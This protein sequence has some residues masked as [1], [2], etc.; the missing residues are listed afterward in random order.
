LVTWT[1]T[2]DLETW[3][4]TTVVEVVEVEPL[5]FVVVEVGVVD[6]ELEAD[7]PRNTK[8]V[9]PTKSTSS[10]TTIGSEGW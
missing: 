7:E 4:C 10:N 6:T 3:S 1:E 2:C 5:W 9:V 8:K